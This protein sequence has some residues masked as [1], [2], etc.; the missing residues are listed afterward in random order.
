MPK[1]IDL[2][3]KV[4]WDYLE[5][6]LQLLFEESLEL[7]RRVRYWDQQFHDYSFIVFPAAKAYEG[8][9]KQF[10]LD[11]GFIEK[12][13]FLG[14]RFRIG[15]ALNPELD[16]KYRKKESVYDRLLTH[17]SGE[18]LPDQLWNTWKESR[19]MLFHWFPNEANIVT[20]PEAQKRV[21][22]IIEA[23]DA[24]FRDCDPHYKN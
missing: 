12:K 13:D 24:V 9:L 1:Y 23:V 4:W 22:M 7:V 14:R 6:D 16:R 20:Y 5:Q 18:A 11:M 3:S 10:F 15:R 21:E 17:C 8:F 19:N 2:H